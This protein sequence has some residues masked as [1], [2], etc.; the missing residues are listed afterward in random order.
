MP[1]RPLLLALAATLTLSGCA[2][3]TADGGEASSPRVL[4]VAD[5]DTGP[6][7]VDAATAVALLDARDDLTIVDV[8]TPQEH[9]SG[10]LEGTLLLDVQ[11]PDFAD[12]L[13]EL[14]PDRAYVVYCRS[15]NRSAVAAAAMAERGFVEVFDAGGYDDL[16]RA[17]AATTR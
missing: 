5:A 16:A 11:A 10:H 14:D 6:V 7:V 13:G 1:L 9:A 17:G 12:R 8:R 4:P 15:G 2:T 3:A